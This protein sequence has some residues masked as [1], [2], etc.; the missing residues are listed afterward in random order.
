MADS[1]LRQILILQKIAHS[2]YGFSTKEIL[3]YVEETGVSASER[4]IQRDI[5]SLCTFFP[6]TQTDSTGPGRSGQRWLMEEIS[7]KNGVPYLSPASAI[8]M[9]LCQ[10]YLEPLFP[11]SMLNQIEPYF[12]EADAVLQVTKGLKV[13][14]WKDKIRIVPNNFL[15]PPEV[16][17]STTENIYKA[18]FENKNFTATF[19]NKH[20][21]FSPYGIVQK[22]HT[23][24][25]LTKF[26]GHN[27]IR[28]CAL[29]R[30]E[31]VEVTTEDTPEDNDFFI[32]NFIDSGAMRWEWEK[33]NSLGLQLECDE[34]LAQLLEETPINTTQIITENTNNTFT[35][36]SQVVD[37]FELRSWLLA[38][39][40]HINDIKPQAIKD[41]LQETG[42]AI[43]KK[44]S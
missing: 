11:A 17:E 35:V 1:A 13:F 40:D 10:E 4:T 20:R 33:H 3:N 7:N 39:S 6:I 24:Y 19:K 22:G 41:W 32:D 43:S 34:W 23:Y 15:M 9:K 31:N 8:I 21:T 2:K 37:N 25:L 36:M 29:H 44:F 18:L 42:L 5:N 38:Y 26:M 14:N 12:K 30:F 27:D 16:S 28:V